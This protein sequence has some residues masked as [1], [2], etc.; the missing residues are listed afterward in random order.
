MQ[1]KEGFNSIQ[2]HLFM[3]SWMAKNEARKESTQRHGAFCNHLI[4][5]LHRAVGLAEKGG[6]AREG[7]GGTPIPFP[8]SGV[9]MH[10]LGVEV[11]NMKPKRMKHNSSENPIAILHC[12]QKIKH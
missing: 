10:I 7:R 5:L 1:R 8:G 2:Q 3:T 12:C 6:S 11:K 4:T 9:L